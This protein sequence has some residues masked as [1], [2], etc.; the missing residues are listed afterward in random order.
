MNLS[1]SELAS[2]VKRLLLTGVSST[3]I[4]SVDGSGSKHKTQQ[5]DLP[6]ELINGM[7]IRY[8]IY[9]GLAGDLLAA[10]I[11]TPEKLAQ[12]LDGIRPDGAFRK[13]SAALWSYLGMKDI[14]FAYKSDWNA[15]YRQIDRSKPKQ[16]DPDFRLKQAASLAAEDQRMAELNQHML[17][18]NEA[19]SA[20]KREE[21]QAFRKIIHTLVRNALGMRHAKRMSNAIE[22]A[23]I[24]ISRTY[25]NEVKASLEGKTMEEIAMIRNPWLED[26]QQIQ[27]YA[28]GVETILRRSAE[29]MNAAMEGISVGERPYFHLENGRLM[30]SASK[31]FSAEAKADIETSEDSKANPGTA[32]PTSG[33]LFSWLFGR[34]K[35]NK[36]A[37]T[38]RK[39]WA[40]WNLNSHPSQLLHDDPQS[41]HRIHSEIR[42][43]VV[44]KGGKRAILV[45]MAW[46]GRSMAVHEFNSS[47]MPS[48]G[49][50]Y[51]KSGNWK[52]SGR[53]HVAKVAKA[54]DGYSFESSHPTQN[55]GGIPTQL[56]MITEFDTEKN[57]PFDYDAFVALAE[58]NPAS[59]GFPEPD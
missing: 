47:G 15:I 56:I 42:S 22:S 31:P 43:E 7:D 25:A 13:Y 29:K 10:Q 58:K 32:T 37:R 19:T 16:T 49:P 28:K 34:K 48:R 5:I 6:A 4:D 40:A 50:Y 59:V 20:R 46:H 2:Y 12:F 26:G 36:P 24:A 3:P 39:A 52:L 17:A 55:G 18:R 41:G 51:V 57:E 11:N 9:L 44:S 54:K 1:D 45:G 53:R 35:S 23:V 38:W 21:D 14:L 33:G 8:W 27:M 30:V